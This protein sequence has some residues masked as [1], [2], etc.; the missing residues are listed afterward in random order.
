[1]IALYFK[2]RLLRTLCPTLPVVSAVLV[3]SLSLNIPI[4]TSDVPAPQRAQVLAIQSLVVELIND[5]TAS[6]V[7]GTAELPTILEI[8]RLFLGLS[9]PPDLPTHR[10]QPASLAISPSSTRMALPDAIPL[11]RLTEIPRAASE[12]E[13]QQVHLSPPP[14]L[15]RDMERYRMKLTPHAPPCTAG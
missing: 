9:D 2:K 14:R 12:G 7:S 13:R 3:A 11:V 4:A 1:M 8:Q 10:G 15:S 5:P 6:N